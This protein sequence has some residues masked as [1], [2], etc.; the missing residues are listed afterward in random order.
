M[1]EEGNIVCSLCESGSAWY[2]LSG[3][4]FHVVK[5]QY[6]G[7]D[8]LVECGMSPVHVDQLIKAPRYSS[9]K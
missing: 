7:K 4:L 5:N 1:T 6:E 9:G 2:E 3:V 8:A